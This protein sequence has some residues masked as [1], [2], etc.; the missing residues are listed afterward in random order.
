M[1][2]PKDAEIPDL[3][4]ASQERSAAGG[5]A[6]SKDA[7]LPRQDAKPAAPRSR[8]PALL[9]RLKAVKLGPKAAV[10]ASLAAGFALGLGVLAFLVL[11]FGAP[12]SGAKKG[13]L[14]GLSSSIR[15]RPDARNR[16]RYL[17]SKGEVFFGLRKSP[18]PK[19]E[20]D[21]GAGDAAMMAEAEA[22]AAAAAAAAEEAM[23]QALE[24]GAESGPG[25][26]PGQLSGATGGGAGGA[27]A[28]LG[29]P[30]EK[31]A[32]APWDTAAPKLTGASGR[33][34][35]RATRKG[36]PTR[37]ALA[38]AN[39][40]RAPGTNK[41]DFSRPGMAVSGA[42]RPAG[43]SAVAESRPSS[44]D[45]LKAGSE[46]AAG[47]APTASAGSEPV[48]GGGG[49]DPGTGPGAGAPPEGETTE[50]KLARIQDL[51]QKSADESDKAHD[52]KKKAAILAA[53]GNHPAAAYHYQRYEKAKKKS[54]KYADQAKQLT[55]DM[56]AQEQHQREQ[57]EASRRRPVQPV[58][59]ESGSSD[60]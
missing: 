36:R 28:S 34:D 22:E 24:D 39:D 20:D 42:A 50:E 4:K 30:A 48:G 23:A 7:I 51:F 13:G 3:K 40:R 55:A 18:L 54:E 27:S 2:D 19:P 32:P 43:S 8:F 31:K 47:A 1:S 15:V 58:E 25:G 29:R 41:G 33:M 5:F 6:W 12:K 56:A 37:A 17:V 45:F 60:P 53:T 52:E 11:E 38:T 46:D 16:L 57:Q 21:S 14:G 9:E 26:R 59:P 35:A 10:A 44:L 49:A